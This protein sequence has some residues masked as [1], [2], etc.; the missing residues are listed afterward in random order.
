MYFTNDYVVA[1]FKKC[2]NQQR[3][4][5]F[6][7]SRMISEDPRAMSNLPTKGFQKIYKLNGVLEMNPF[8]DYEVTR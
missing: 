5:E 3:K 7:D 6:L 4:Q 1:E 8:I 2:A